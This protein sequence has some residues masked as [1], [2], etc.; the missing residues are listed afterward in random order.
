MSLKHR[1]DAYFSLLGHYKNVFK[2]SWNRRHLSG[3]KIFNHDEAEFLPAAL[4]LQEKPVS[5]TLRN[6]AKILI[7]LL[8][9]TI[10][11]SI[12]GKIDIIV[13]GMGKV[14]PSERTK[15]ISSVDVATLRN[16][17]VRD[18]QEVKKGDVLMELDT[19]AFD[20]EYNKASD[21]MM[22]STLQID[23]A[24]ALL[25]AIDTRKA[26]VLNR[27]PSIPIEKWETEKANLD[28]QYREFNA[29]IKS[30]DDGIDHYK[31]LLQIAIKQ[32]Q[33]Y[34]ELAETHDVSFHDWQEKE[35]LKIETENRLTDAKNQKSTLISEIKK[36]CYDT[37]IEAKKALKASSEDA[38]R[39]AEHSKSLKLT[40]PVN[41]TVQQLSVYTLGS[42]VP[43]TQSL[44]EI[45]PDKDHIEIEAFIENKDIG[46]IEPNQNV[47]VKI[48]TFD[49][50]KYGT[51]PGKVITISRDAI[52]DQQRGLIYSVKVLLDKTSLSVNGKKVHLS[53]GMSARI[54]IK[55]GTRRIIEYFLSPLMQHQHESLHER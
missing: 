14:I 46:F 8:S 37:I 32:A 10:V 7:L 40:S 11:W 35:K 12:F 47:M 2:H 17:Y 23:H 50:T 52:E 39:S 15:V 43:A 53:P 6:V 29:R 1:M 54:E 4:S 45:V 25:D 16:L 36:S 9:V 27:N 33:D 28:A 49:Y 18:G 24:R 38:Y 13:N 55:T 51:I 19:S 31:S 3:S 26:P 5:P 42:A 48:D 22:S 30:F 41:G 20:T 21:V 44:M 34:R